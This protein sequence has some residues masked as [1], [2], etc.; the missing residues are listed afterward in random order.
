M[1][2]EM[3]QESGEKEN[4]IT[5]EV[6]ERGWWWKW[7]RRA[8]EGEGGRAALWRLIRHPRPSVH[9]GRRSSRTVNSRI[10]HFKH[11]FEAQ[12]PTPHAQDQCRCP[13]IGRKSNTRGI[14]WSGN[15]VSVF[16]L[17]PPSLGVRHVAPR[18]TTQSTAILYGPQTSGVIPDLRWLR[19]A[20]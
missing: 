13:N 15:F 6:R 5:G 16:L 11:C 7:G 3:K 8:E 10:C 18:M 19:A 14:D 2:E 20:R 9:D 17:E 4:I 12:T 1:T